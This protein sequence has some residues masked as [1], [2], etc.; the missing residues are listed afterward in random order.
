MVYLARKNGAATVAE[1]AWSESIPRKFLPCIL[2]DRRTRGLVVGRR[3]PTG[4]HPLARDANA[5]GFADNLRSID[6]PLAL[7]PCNQPP[8]IHRP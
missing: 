5:I 4:G 1:I 3:G 8:D 7:T 6:G 2:S